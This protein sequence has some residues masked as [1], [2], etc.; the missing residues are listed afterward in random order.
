VY[1]LNQQQD[2]PRLRQS[3]TSFFIAPSDKYIAPTDSFCEFTKLTKGLSNDYVCLALTPEL[4]EELP[5]RYPAKVPVLETELGWVG[6][7]HRTVPTKPIFFFEPLMFVY[8]HKG[9]RVL[10]SG[11][12]IDY[13]IKRLFAAV[14]RE[15]L[16]N[17]SLNLSEKYFLVRVFKNFVSSFMNLPIKL[18]SQKNK[19]VL[20]F[21]ALTVLAV[22]LI[23]CISTIA[24]FC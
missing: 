3:W 21:I 8:A 15:V 23:F 2:T 4:A 10:K 9:Y 18:E 22:L 24:I 11:L 12:T 16:L 20:T 5:R 17:F 14:N 13:Y 7:H 19:P 1:L 6:R